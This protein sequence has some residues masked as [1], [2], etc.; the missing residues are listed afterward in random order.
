MIMGLIPSQ[1]KTVY[2]ISEL[3]MPIKKTCIR[4]NLWIF[5]NFQK[6]LKMSFKTKKVTGE[7]R[8]N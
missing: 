5:K 7:E 4:L 6:N 3:F 2:K 8:K 1:G